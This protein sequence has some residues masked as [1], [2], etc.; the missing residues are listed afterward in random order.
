MLISHD[1]GPKNLSEIIYIG[2]PFRLQMERCSMKTRRNGNKV[3]LRR[4]LLNFS[5][6]ES[7]CYILRLGLTCG[8]LRIEAENPLFYEVS[9]L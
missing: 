9:P 4:A 5:F 6:L 8:T 1:G 3:I 2:N 7:L